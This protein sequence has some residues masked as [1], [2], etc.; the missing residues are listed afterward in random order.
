ME[1][2]NENKLKMCIRCGKPNSGNHELWMPDGSYYGDYC[3]DCYDAVN[4][5]VEA[6]WHY[7]YAIPDFIIN[8]KEEA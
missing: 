5:A 6:W 4:Q 1:Q 8:P 2:H 7:G 3:T